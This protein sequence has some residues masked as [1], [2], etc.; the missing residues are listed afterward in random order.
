MF[1]FNKI[2]YWICLFLTL[3][4]TYLAELCLDLIINRA[5]MLVLWKLILSNGNGWSRAASSALLNS[6]SAFSWVGVELRHSK[7]SSKNSLSSSGSVLSI[8]GAG[9]SESSSHFG[10]ISFAK[11]SSSSDFDSSEE[12]EHKMNPKKISNFVKFVIFKFVYVVHTY[13]THQWSQGFGPEPRQ[14]Y[15]LL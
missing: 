2:Q 5:E 14:A 3:Y 11:R 10:V 9:S 13:M 4:S 8:V 12:I 7:F 1:L 15:S 6:N